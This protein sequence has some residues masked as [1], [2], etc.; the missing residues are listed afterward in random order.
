MAGADIYLCVSIH[1]AKIIYYFQI[2]IHHLP[3]INPNL[4]D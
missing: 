3:Q 1:I 2:F 4:Q